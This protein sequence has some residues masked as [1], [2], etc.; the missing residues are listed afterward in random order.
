MTTPV[1]AE[2]APM[3]L[4]AVFGQFPGDTYPCCIGAM[5]CTRWEIIPDDEWQKVVLGWKQEWDRDWQS[6]DYREAFI[7]FTPPAVA[8]PVL[9]A[10]QKDTKEETGQ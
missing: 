4:R 10:Q 2:L 3:K 9:Q 1:K 8:A 5:D 7:E 6:Y